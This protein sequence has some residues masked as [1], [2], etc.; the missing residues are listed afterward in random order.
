MTNGL[1][2]LLWIARRVTDSRIKPRYN[3]LNLGQKG[4]M[5]FSSKWSF[6][7]WLVFPFCFPFF[8]AQ[9]LWCWIASGAV[10]SRA[11]H[12]GW[13]GDP[14]PPGWEGET[15]FIFIYLLQNLCFL[16]KWAETCWGNFVPGYWLSPSCSAGVCCP[17]T[18]FCFSLLIIMVEM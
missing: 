11:A 18:P 13:S 5:L 6:H 16:W 10:L 17:N 8:L 3:L 9:Q 4:C 12:A 14:S 15:H 7:L 2:K 1:A